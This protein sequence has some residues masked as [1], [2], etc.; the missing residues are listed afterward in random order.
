M[1]VVVTVLRQLLQLTQADVLIWE[2]ESQGDYSASYRGRNL[3]LNCAATRPYLIVDAVRHSVR[4][5]EAF[6]VCNEIALQAARQ[7]QK[8]LTQ[9]HEFIDWLSSQADTVPSGAG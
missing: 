5:K 2:Y 1:P 8:K 7:Q 3:R 4:Q 9:L 6:A